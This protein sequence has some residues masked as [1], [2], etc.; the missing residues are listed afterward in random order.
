VDSDPRQRDWSLF[1]TVGLSPQVVTE[2]CWALLVQEPTPII[3][4][5]VVLLATRVGVDLAQQLVGDDGMLARLYR[6]WAPGA[7][8]PTVSISLISSG[9]LL[10]PHDDVDSNEAAYASGQIVLQSLASL[11]RDAARGIL[12]LLSGGRKTMAYHVGL[13]F[14]LYARSWDRLLHVLVPPA[15]ERAPAFYFPR[16]EAVTI[17]NLDGV[18]LDASAPVVKLIDV[19]YV[20]LG[21]IRQLLERTE[22]LALTVRAVNSA[23]NPQISLRADIGGATLSWSGYDLDLRPSSMLL[24]AALLRRIAHGDGWLRAPREH[25][26]DEQLGAELLTI[27]KV[28]GLRIDRRTERVIRGG[29][30][31]TWLRPR[32]S[33]LNTELAEQT[34]RALRSL[35]IKSRGRAP[36]LYRLSIEREEIAPELRALLYLDGEAVREPF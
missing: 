8:I 25:V 29:V 36:R 31:P 18:R 2:A 26:R 24:F 12:A 20:R 17:V 4:T 21:G 13:A 27:A 3:P 30:E 7:A 6:E 34:S 1:A 14:S 16:R 15:Y 10:E 33:R 22:D 32:L 5:D 9:D 35:S 23:L 11:T 19:P 28:L